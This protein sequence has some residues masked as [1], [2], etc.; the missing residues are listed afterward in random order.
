FTFSSLGNTYKL[1]AGR[2]KPGQYAYSAQVNTNGKVLVKKGIFYVKELQVEASQTQA[3]HQLLYMMAQNTKG[4]M[5]FPAQLD[6]LEK[7]IIENQNIVSL[8]HS[9]KDIADLIRYKLLFF[10]IL[11]FL[12]LEWF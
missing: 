2:F 12:S 1:N 8:V 11:I 9:S 3:N 4:E 10:V 5:Y 6:L 7:K